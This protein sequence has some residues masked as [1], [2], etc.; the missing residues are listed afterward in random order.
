MRLKHHDVS[1]RHDG[2]KIIHHQ[3]LGDDPKIV[4]TPHSKIWRGREPN[5]QDVLRSDTSKRTAHASRKKS[6]S[7]VMTQLQK[8]I[9][10]NVWVCRWQCTLCRLSKHHVPEMMLSECTKRVVTARMEIIV[11]MIGR[12]TMSSRHHV[13]KNRWVMS[14]IEK[15]NLWKF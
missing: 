15:L 14:G 10:Q 3:L 8:H 2:V 13:S 12:F 11:S 5:R 6:S 7:Y 4:R 1:R 9:S